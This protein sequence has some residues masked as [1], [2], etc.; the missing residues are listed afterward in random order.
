MI[1]PSFTNR[2]ESRKECNNPRVDD[3]DY[4]KDPVDI[5]EELV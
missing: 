4:G 1:H 3:V 2:S 5:G